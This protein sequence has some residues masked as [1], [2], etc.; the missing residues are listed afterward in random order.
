MRLLYL[1]AD[2]GIPVLGEKGGSVHLRSMAC[3][4]R[5][6]GHEVLVA[7][8]RVEKG[9]EPLPREI[10]L[11]EV[12]AVRP[13]ECA[14]PDEVHRQMSEQAQAVAELAEREQAEAIYERYSLAACA[15]ARAS[16][17]LG[18]PLVIEVN[19]PLREEERAFRHLV[20]EEAAL[21]AERETFAAADRIFAVSRHLAAWLAGLGIEEE[22]LEVMPNAPPRRD[23]RGRRERTDDRPL[24][25]GFAGGLRPWHGIDVL[26][27]AVQLA[28][29]RGAELRLEVL[30][31]GPAE[32]MLDRS[33][34]PETRLRRY[35]HLPHGEALAML[36]RWDVGVAPYPPLP[37]FYFSPLK[38]LEY[39]AAGLCPVVSDVG[40]LPD[41]V[42]HGRSGV[43][44][45]AGD[46]DALADALVA[47][48]RERALV[49][50]LAE[51][52]QAAASR[53]PSWSDNAQRVIAAIERARTWSP[54]GAGGARR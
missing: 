27:E 22:R 34:L 1:S 29:E 20:H 2:P 12:P 30:G 43:V 36:E 16:Q 24:V 40:E 28:L 3:A 13:R 31:R 51:G 25:V 37:G 53:L 42:E 46:A 7:S 38:L 35:G 49:R 4:L 26:V 41:V 50:R 32:E 54:A 39:M 52:A 19:A 8:P 15:G 5:E 44:V 17:E 18:L 14:T 9:P 11:I 47:L 23:L 33:G 6:L 48:D 10:V 21:A 45:P